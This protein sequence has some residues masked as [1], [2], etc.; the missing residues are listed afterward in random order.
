[1]IHAIVMVWCVPAKA[2]FD[3]LPSEYKVIDGARTRWCPL[4]LLDAILSLLLSHSNIFPTRR[5]FCQQ[6]VLLH[7]ILDEIYAINSG[8][9][10]TLY[11]QEYIG[12]FSAISSQLA[13]PPTASK[14]SSPIMHETSIDTFHESLALV[15]MFSGLEIKQSSLKW[16]SI[17]NVCNHASEDPPSKSKSKYLS[18][19]QFFFQHFAFAQ[20]G[21][22]MEMLY[23]AVISKALLWFGS[24]SLS[25]NEGQF[26]PHQ[27]LSITEFDTVRDG[28]TINNNDHLQDNFPIEGKMDINQ[29]E[30]N[31]QEPNERWA[32]GLSSSPA[33]SVSLFLYVVNCN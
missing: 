2:H 9:Y 8:L 17:T 24:H 30:E 32:V 23:T 21:V 19:V 1:M 4:L 25:F 31:Q 33:L 12:A 7:C 26:F 13:Q 5:A 29:N 18:I 10:M 22:S 3:T 6:Q 14:L 16:S 11:Q 20:C 27:A 28:D 15:N